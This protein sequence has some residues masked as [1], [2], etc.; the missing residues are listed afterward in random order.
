MQLRVCKCKY[1]LLGCEWQGKLS[2]VQ[3]HETSCEFL[4]K[5]PD[6]MIA[7]LQRRKTPIKCDKVMEL[8]R[9]SDTCIQGMT[10]I[11]IYLECVRNKYNGDLSAT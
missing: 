3:Q 4:T 8:I 6:E 10:I 11:N 7:C 1:S 2:L 9:K 5:S